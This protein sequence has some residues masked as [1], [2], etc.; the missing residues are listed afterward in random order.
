MKPKLKVEA[1]IFR[2]RRSKEEEL[3]NTLLSEAAG[4][5][6]SQFNQ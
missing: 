4:A 2:N 5:Q 3:Q 6:I 1:H